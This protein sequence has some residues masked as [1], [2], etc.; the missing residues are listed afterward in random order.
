MVG[1]WG[2][3]NG[4]SFFV[5]AVVELIGIVVNEAVDDKWLLFVDGLTIKD[6]L[7]FDLVCVFGLDLESDCLRGGSKYIYLETKANI[8]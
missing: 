5:E 6:V 7:V 8:E 3:F 1:D 4:S 2:V